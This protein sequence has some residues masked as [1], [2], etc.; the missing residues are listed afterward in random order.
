MRGIFGINMVP[1]EIV[2]RNNFHSFFFFFKFT[3]SK[4]ITP[5][6]QKGLVRVKENEKTLEEKKKKKPQKTRE[7][8][9]PVQKT[10]RS[11]KQTTDKLN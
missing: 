5:S 8:F 11:V 6:I 9:I 1:K 4:T 3:Q 7:T 10:V 2:V